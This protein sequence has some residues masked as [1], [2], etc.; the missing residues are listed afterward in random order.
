[1]GQISEGLTGFSCSE[2]ASEPRHWLTGSA[3]DDVVVVLFFF[4]DH[5]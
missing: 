2:K 1:M 5:K 4:L 3:D